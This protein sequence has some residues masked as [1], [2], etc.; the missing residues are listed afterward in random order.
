[1]PRANL[2]INEELYK[3]L[4]KAADKKH[5]TVNSLIIEELEAKYSKNTTYDYTAALQNIVAEAKQ[6]ENEFTLAQLETFADVADVIKEYKIKASPASVRA[7]LGK[8][9]NEAVRN[10]VV[11]G[12][13][14][15]VVVKNG[16]KAQKFY[17]RAAV[18]VNTKKTKK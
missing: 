4:K 12:V 16:K 17:C 8:M 11:P 9:F 6:K 3:Q 1:M 15:A 10:G 13:E 14:R 7:K 18:Y 5:I 2:S